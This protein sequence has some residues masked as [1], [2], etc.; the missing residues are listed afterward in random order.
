LQSLLLLLLLLHFSLFC[1]PVILSF[2][3]RENMKHT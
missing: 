1:P 2:A 3:R